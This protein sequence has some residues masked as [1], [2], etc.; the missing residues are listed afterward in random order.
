MQNNVISI[1]ITSLYVSQPSSVTFASKTADLGP[2]L[3]VSIG[4]RSHLFFVL[5]SKQRL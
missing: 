2:E 1:K 5:F 3:Q 4:P